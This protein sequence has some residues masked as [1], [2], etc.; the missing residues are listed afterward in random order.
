MPTRI[1][2]GIKLASFA[3]GVYLWE[4]SGKIHGETEVGIARRF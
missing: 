1:K 4:E 3:R 2:L